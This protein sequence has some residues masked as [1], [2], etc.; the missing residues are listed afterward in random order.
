M[1][2]SK[3]PSHIPQIGDLLRITPIKIDYTVRHYKDFCEESY[4]TSRFFALNYEGKPIIE[5]SLGGAMIHTLSCDVE[6]AKYRT[7]FDNQLT[8]VEVEKILE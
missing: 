1:P 7:L 8:L 4:V 2:T 6:E 3:F 5:V